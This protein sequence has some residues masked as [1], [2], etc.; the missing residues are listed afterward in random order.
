MEDVY[1]SAIERQLSELVN[2][3]G[4]NKMKLNLG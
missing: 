3:F 4:E 1:M 2:N